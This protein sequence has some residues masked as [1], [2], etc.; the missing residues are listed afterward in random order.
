MLHKYVISPEKKSESW[1]KKAKKFS[2]YIIRY[3]FKI[4]V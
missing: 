1:K 4:E 3:A 2:D